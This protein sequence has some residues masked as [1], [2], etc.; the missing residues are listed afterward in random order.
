MQGRL[1]KKL[2][3]KDF[4][5]LLDSFINPYKMVTDKVY[6]AQIFNNKYE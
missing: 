4:L 1:I 5:I 3:D 6:F 2:I